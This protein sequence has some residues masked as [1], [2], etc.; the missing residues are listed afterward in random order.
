MKNQIMFLLIGAFQGKDG[1]MYNSV[2]HKVGRGKV[3]IES[4]VLTFEQCRNLGVFIDLNGSLYKMYQGM[5]IA[6]GFNLAISFNGDIAQYETGVKL[7]LAQRGGALRS[8]LATCVS[9]VTDNI[10]L[11]AEHYKASMSKIEGDLPDSDT[12]QGQVFYN[13]DLYDQVY[14]LYGH[15]PE[16]FNAT[17]ADMTLD[18]RNLMLLY[19]IVKLFEN[20]NYK[21]VF[22]YEPFYGPVHVPAPAPDANDEAN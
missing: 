4:E 8:M 7:K 3:N 22:V 20:A 6:N 21:K 19:E 16:V 2:L 17:Y 14:K 18:L 1:Q 5:L 10:T 11:L 15:S 9:L 12:T 13:I